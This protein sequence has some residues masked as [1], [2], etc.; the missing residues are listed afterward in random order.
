MASLLTQC[1]HCQTSFRVSRP[2]LGA[3]NGQVRCGACLGVFSAV[4]NEIRV[5]PAA[6][7]TS[8]SWLDDDPEPAH[9]APTPAPGASWLDDD[10]ATAAQTQDPHPRQNSSWLDDEPPTLDLPVQE[11]AAAAPQ[12]ENTGQAP[13]E[14]PAWVAETR[15]DASPWEE[16]PPET[17]PDWDAE[18]RWEAPTPEEVPNWEGA[19]HEADPPWGDEPDQEPDDA[20]DDEPD[21][22]PELPE[23][24]APAASSP[25][26]QA[27]L[28]NATLSARHEDVEEY[29][30]EDGDEDEEAAEPFA[31]AEPFMGVDTD[32]LEDDTPPLFADHDDDPPLF[33]THDDDP[34]LEQDDADD[35]ETVRTRYAAEEPARGAAKAR[36]RGYLEDLE[37]DDALEE[38]GPD[39]LEYVDEEPLTIAPASAAGHLWRNLALGLGSLALLGLLGL[40]YVASHLD[41]L[42][43][44][45]RFALFRP[46][47]CAVLTCPP[48]APL[49][50]QFATQQLVV[51][52][53]PSVRNALEVSFIFANESTRA[54]P[55][56]TLALSF[57]DNQDHLVAS[58]RFVPE[59][60][61]PPELNALG[62]MPPASSVQVQ[63]EIVDP[64]ND[65]TR[66]SITY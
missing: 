4:A 48:P 11:P 44:S 38:L 12:A 19:A 34:L 57:H 55:F 16:D 65:A 50:A 43:S 30:D 42:N 24:S 8:G 6:P 9:D 15:Q 2:Q 13:E 28:W 25:P 1:P 26:A 58:R 62:T 63:L 20:P 41:A 60:Y 21:W 39:T 17:E 54:Q 53:H 46:T 14:M 51:R 47:L 23:D 32:E 37:D 7:L 52:A 22:E 66:Y 18:P 31:R 33:A 56:P 10:A 49:P 29:T 64:G 27:P 3:A 45:T 5:K 61:L 40:Q 59:E 36:L 35:Y